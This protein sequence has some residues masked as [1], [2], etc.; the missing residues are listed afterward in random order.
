VYQTYF[1]DGNQVMLIAPGDVKFVD[2]NGDGYITPGKNTFGDPGDQ[3]VIGNS[4]PRYE[5][6]LRLGADYKGF[7]ASIFFQGIGKRKIWGAGQLAIPGYFPKEGAMPQAIAENYW[8]EDRTDA[9]YP[10][11]WNLGGSNE[12]FVMRKQNRYMLNMAY[13]KIKNITFGYS[14]PQNILH[15]IYL[16]NARVYVSLENFFTF[17]KLRGLPIDPEAISGYSP[18]K[19]SGY[20]SDRTGTGN[21]SFKSASV[22]VQISL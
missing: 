9:F 17:D 20:N 21:P 6:G 1:E 13:M 14:F 11:A 8:R 5:Y 18:L 12:G 4:T 10:R 15:H 22:G 7:D 3:V 16:S 2:V 19:S